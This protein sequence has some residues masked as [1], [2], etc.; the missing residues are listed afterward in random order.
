MRDTKEYI[1]LQRVR[2]DVWTRVSITS[3]YSQRN[4]RDLDALLS[5]SQAHK[6]LHVML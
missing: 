5:K 6:W 4:Q 1:P 2:A 3:V